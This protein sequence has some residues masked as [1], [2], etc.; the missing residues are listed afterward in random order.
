MQVKVIK[1]SGFWFRIKLLWFKIRH[2]CYKCRDE[3]YVFVCYA[4]NQRCIR[5]D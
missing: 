4:I 2:K 1:T 5:E 3:R